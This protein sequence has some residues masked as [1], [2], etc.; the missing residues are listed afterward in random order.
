M[1]TITA[2]L[3]MMT[4]TGTPSA[5]PAQGEAP[6]GLIWG[7]SFQQV[8]ALGISLSASSDQSFGKSY[9]A[10][11][12][13][14][15]IGDAELVLLAFGHD[16]KLWRIAMAGASVKNDPYGSSV[17]RRYEELSGAL[18]EK[19]G[20]GKQEHF[21][22]RAYETEHFVMGIKGGNNWWYTNFA[23]PTV[24]V[25]IAIG[26]TDYT[27]PYWRLIYTNKA[28]SAGFEKSKK[29]REKNAL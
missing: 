11:N 19:Y 3:M 12:L 8:Q 16:D 15:V 5:Q 17:K 9:S 18:A 26:A 20:K 22:A 10:T 13:P 4:V 6:L 28:L 21:A 7:M 23:N 29:E 2:L 27:S 24:T 14:K 25:Q 1:R